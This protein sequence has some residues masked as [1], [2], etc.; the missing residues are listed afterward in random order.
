LRG[1]LQQGSLRNYNQQ[2]KS[3]CMKKLLKS[4]LIWY[5][6][7]EMF[8]LV[9]DV[10]QYVHFLPWC[11]HSK[12]LQFNDQGMDA[13]VGIG[14]AGVS[15]VF[16]THNTHI[17]NHEIRMK[18]VQGPFSNLDGTWTFDPVGD[19]SQRACK[20]TLSLE[21]GFSSATLAAVVGPVFDK[22]AASLVDAFV[23]RAEQVYGAESV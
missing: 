12:V 1:S 19:N 10:D 8:R 14:V 2:N 16:V 13:E 21:Y 18:L 7:E 11:N 23:K 17:L 22:I 20:V 5:T 6:P 9:T 3:Y 4:V 15:Q